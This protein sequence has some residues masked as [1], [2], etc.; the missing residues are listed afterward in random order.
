MIDH[1]SCIIPPDGRVSADQLRT[2]SKDVQQQQHN[3]QAPTTTTVT[4]TTTSSTQFATASGG[5]LVDYRPIA[6]LDIWTVPLGCNEGETSTTQY[7]TSRSSH[8]FVMHCSK[9]LI[10]G[11]MGAFV[12]Y[13]FQD[14]MEACATTN[15]F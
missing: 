10:G 2:S 6:P 7:W 12:A 15:E 1:V 13:S 4:V 5:L 8:Q 9:G 14:C 3:T 11:D